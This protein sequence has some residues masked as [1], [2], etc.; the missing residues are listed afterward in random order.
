MHDPSISMANPVAVAVVAFNPTRPARRQQPPTPG[1]IHK[2]IKLDAIA[3]I[4]HLCF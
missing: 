4:Y 1:L 3:I 2:Q